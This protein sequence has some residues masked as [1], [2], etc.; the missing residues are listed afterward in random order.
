MEDTMA[1]ENSVV[2][3]YSTHAKAEAA[4]KAL[5]SS[6]FNMKQL[7]IVGKDY[8]SEEQ[9]VGYYNTGDRMKAWGKFGAFWGGLWGLLFGS[10]FF[11]IPGIGPL[12]VGGPLVTWI[13]G[14]LEGAALMGGLSAL[15]GALFSIG[16]PKDSIVK[17][18]TAIRAG[19]FVL[20]AH[21]T[22]AEV[23]RAREVLSSTSPDDSA[24]H[25]A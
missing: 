10:A 1:R 23:S 22:M 3:I 19:K 25:P 5:Q 21:G 9:P 24:L 12:V 16:V 2:C 15:G 8:H 6:G 20:L 7:S 14:A 18:E 4:V 11:L 13:V 17:Y